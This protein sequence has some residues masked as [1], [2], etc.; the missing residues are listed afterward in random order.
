MKNSLK[1][2]QEVFLFPTT[3]NGLE[4]Q[5][6]TE[7]IFLLF[8]YKIEKEFNGNIV[9]FADR[10]T[11]IGENFCSANIFNY[12]VQSHKSIHSLFLDTRLQFPA[13]CLY[14]KFERMLLPAYQIRTTLKMLNNPVA[15]HRQKKTLNFFLNG[16]QFLV[17]E[18]T[19][20]HF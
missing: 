12:S 14:V 6:K 13:I 8:L 11:K 4:L 18:T 17:L 5:T 20:V 19:I 1:K 3:L 7:N 2:S 9:T 10:L 16:M 15:V